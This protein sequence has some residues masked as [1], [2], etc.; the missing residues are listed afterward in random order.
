MY[1]LAIS[2]LRQLIGAERISFR[3]ENKDMGKYFDTIILSGGFDPVEQKHLNMFRAA[4]QLACKVVVGL[5]SDEWLQK[6]KGALNTP[7][8]ARK[9]ALEALE[10]VHEVLSFDDSDGTAQALISSLDAAYPTHDLAFGNGGNRKI[11]NTPE[12]EI[13]QKLGIAQVWGVGNCFD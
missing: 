8:L 4:S 3:A 1:G 9:E 13:C 6:H 11:Q 2:S 10:N 7:F 12:V 5:N